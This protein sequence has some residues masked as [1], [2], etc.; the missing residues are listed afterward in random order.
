MSHS[1]TFGLLLAAAFA[2]SA[3]GGSG[4]SDQVAADPSPASSPSP[5]PSPSLRAPAVD[6]DGVP[7]P[8]PGAPDG[9][10]RIRNACFS[11]AVPTEAAAALAGSDACDPSV[12]YDSGSFSVGD[13]FV[14]DSEGGPAGADVDALVTLVQKVKPASDVE[15]RMFG[16]QPGALLRSPVANSTVNEVGYAAVIDLRAKKISYQGQPVTNLVFFGG[17]GSDDVPEDQQVII[18]ALES[19]RFG[20]APAAAAQAPADAGNVVTS[21]FSLTLPAPLAAQLG[22]ARA[23][24]FNVRDSTANFGLTSSSSTVTIA[25]RKATEAGEAGEKAY[26]VEDLLIDGQPGVLFGID[27]DTGAGD[28]GDRRFEI[29]FDLSGLD[30]N[31]AGRPVKSLTLLSAADE[32]QVRAVLDSITWAD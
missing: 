4:E 1:R 13:V 31:D 2:L 3:C 23:C 17:S 11:I 28:S 24:S 27:P 29:H 15:K 19:L 30:L 16:G 8:L 26:E 25:Q 21:C 14:P 7:G 20:D 22:G 5:E 32:A 18:A 12:N 10:T 9:F 6:A